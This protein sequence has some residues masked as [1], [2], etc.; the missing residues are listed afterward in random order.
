MTRNCEP[1]AGLKFIIC[2]VIFFFACASSEAAQVEEDFILGVSMHFMRDDYAVKLVDSI[3]QEA[4]QNP[5]ATVIVTDANGAPQKQLADVENLV[6]Q[7]VDAIIVVP[8]DEKAILPAIRQANKANIPVVAI[9]TIPGAEVVSTI[10]ASGDYANGKAS[11]ELLREATGGK[12]KLAMIGIP[13]SLWRI[14]ERE[15]GFMDAI[16]GTE[17]EVVAR[18][19]G[20][21]QAKVQDAVAGILIAHPDLAGIWCAFSNQ[22]VGAADALRTANRKSVV[23]TGI[24]ADKAIIERIRKGWITGAAAQFPRE[25][26]Q[27]A[28]EAAFQAFKDKPVP[29][30]FEVPVGLVTAENADLMEEQIWGE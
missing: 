21:D 7:G 8:I 12:G 9:T 2:T 5:G 29:P 10:A 17:L 11:G 20:L 30:S 25:Q 23:L 1:R 16:A 13:Y 4:S 15:R 18:Q 27:L 28:A 19:S 14:D 26:G 3:Q 22:L 6:V 24:D